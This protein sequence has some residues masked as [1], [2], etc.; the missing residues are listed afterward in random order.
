M[1][2][3]NPDY[4]EEIHFTFI[5][6]YPIALDNEWVYYATIH[7]YKPQTTPQTKLRLNLWSTSSYRNIDHSFW[8]LSTAQAYLNYKKERE[9]STKHYWRTIVKIT[10][11][12]WVLAFKN[13][14]PHSSNRICLTKQLQLTSIN[15][16]PYMQLWKYFSLCVCS[17][18]WI[19]PF[20]CR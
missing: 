8:R 4:Q 11:A 18:L 13:Y 5:Q 15:T 10:A 1:V 20:L 3:H 12:A 19:C 16:T 17:Y 9:W 6:N 2:L 14:W 7:N